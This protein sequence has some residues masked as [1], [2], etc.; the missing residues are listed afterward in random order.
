MRKLSLLILLISLK[1]FGQSLETDRQALIAI[2]NKADGPNWGSNWVVPGNVGDSPCGWNGVT[3]AGNRVTR[4][5]LSHPSPKTSLPAEIGNLSELTHLDLWTEDLGPGFGGQIPSQLGNLSKL[6]YLRLDG[7]YFDI[8]DV[9]VIGNL[10]NLR[11]LSMNPLGNIPASF[12]NLVNLERCTISRSG[13]F[14]VGAAQLAFP[15]AVYQWPKI[16]YLRIA[17]VTFTTPMSSQIGSLT[18]LDSLELTGA[19]PLGPSPRTATWGSIPA[20]IGNLTNLRYLNLSS[21]GLTGPIPAPFNNLTNLK[22]DLSYNNLT[23]PIPNIPGIPVAADVRIN[24]NAFNFDGMESNISR[25]DSYSP[26]A[27]I[28]AYLGGPLCLGCIATEMWVST[29]GGTKANNTYKLYKDVLPL[30]GEGVYYAEV[31]NSAVPELTLRTQ[32]FISIKLPVTLVSFEGHSENNQTKLTWKT[33]SETNNKGFEIE[34]SADARTF[35]K[36]GFVDGS[37]D[38]KEM[39]VYHFTDPA[40]FSNTYYR[41]KQI[42]FDGQFEYSKV[43][44]VGKDDAIANVFPNPAQDYLIVKGTG[45]K[46]PFSIVDQNGRV[47]FTGFVTDRVQ[48]NLINLGTGRYVVR[49]GEESSRLLIHR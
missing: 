40:P 47:A 28:K 4:L 42:D 21:N 8:Q 12:A 2:Y 6:Q 49:V 5:V 11:E 10:T 46:Q 24:N 20:E 16:K 15:D 41:L 3:C 45:Q 33:I 25:L 32:T 31:T 19:G 1:S 44:A 7:N 14:A 13:V 34:R 9:S 17:N 23:G 27:L 18:T 43:V 48:V 26:Q 38:T 37:G 22:L 35:E 29:A 39:K 36:I 30:D